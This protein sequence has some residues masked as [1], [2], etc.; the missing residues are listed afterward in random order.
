[1]VKGAGHTMAFSVAHD[2]FEQR[3]LEFLGSAAGG[4]RSETPA[5]QSAPGKPN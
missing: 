5:A 1:M 4:G 3:V 2:E